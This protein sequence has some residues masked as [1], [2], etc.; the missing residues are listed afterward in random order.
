MIY[1]EIVKDTKKINIAE[2]MT[3]DKRKHVVFMTPEIFTKVFSPE[4]IKLLTYLK[5]HK[6]QS[7]SDLA[8]K[9]GRKFEAVH[10][11][12]RYLDRFVKLKR[13]EANKVPY[14]DEGIN[15]EMIPA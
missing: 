14:V 7:I 15:I 12:I 1:I 4:R 9:L 3:N 11:D 8:R 2:K 13:E 6:V 10:R 5:E